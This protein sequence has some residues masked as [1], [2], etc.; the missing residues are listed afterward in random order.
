MNILLLKTKNCIYYF[1]GS[2]RNGDDCNFSHINLKED[3]SYCNSSIEDLIINEQT[4]KK[5]TICKNFRNG[6]KCK[7]GIKCWFSHFDE[8]C[9]INSDISANIIVN[10]YN[11]E[12]KLNINDQ[13]INIKSPD[14]NCI[15][16]P[17]V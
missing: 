16:T 15:N 9:S 5:N 11:K 6:N 12:G 1:K 7:F 13:N 10:E 2:C 14:D 4:K 3:Q 8:V 17:V